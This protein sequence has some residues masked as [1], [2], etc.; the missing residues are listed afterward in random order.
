M[1][2][3]LRD[4]IDDFACG[5]WNILN[6]GFDE[7]IDVRKFVEYLNGAVT[8]CEEIP[9]GAD[10]MLRKNGDA[11]EILVRKSMSPERTRFTIAHEIGHLFLHCGYIVNQGKWEAADDVYLEGEYEKEI[12]ANEFARALLMPKSR[13]R[14]YIEDHSEGNKVD[15]ASVARSFHVSIAS[16]V[17]RAKKL[18]III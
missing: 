1:S 11:F 15:M 17:S 6:I 13:F 7:R 14:A 5:I 16:A 8:P 3:E 10:G 12:Q 18:K 4:L 9:E 2:E